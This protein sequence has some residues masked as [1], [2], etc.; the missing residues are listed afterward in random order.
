LHGELTRIDEVGHMTVTGF[1]LDHL[2]TT[3]LPYGSD[4]ISG[5]ISMR[6]LYITTPIVVGLFMLRDV[7]R[8]ISLL[9]LACAAF[10]IASNAT[11]FALAARVIPPLGYSRFPAA[12]YRALV[13]LPLLVLGAQA[14]VE[15]RQAPP[16]RILRAV[17]FAAF[18]AL[19]MYRLHETS[20]LTVV[21]AAAS[22]TLVVL[23]PRWP[24]AL[25]FTV[26]L[27]AIDAHHMHHAVEMPWI[28]PASVGPFKRY[29]RELGKALTSPRTSRPARSPARYEV[30]HGSPDLE[31][32]LRGHYSNDDYAASEHLRAVVAA[33][34][35]PA[36][37]DFLVAASHPV[38]LPSS[39][40][41][42]GP[43]AVV[44]RE[45]VGTARTV[46]FSA[47]R[48]EYALEVPPN[49]IVVENEP[50]MMGWS[51]ELDC[52]PSR[53][54]LPR[55]ELYPLRTWSVPGGTQRLC[56]R[57]ETPKRRFGS[58]VSLA[59]LALYLGLLIYTAR[60]RRT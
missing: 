49:A 42:T 17:G 26:P 9:M 21:I 46:A 2:F 52:D 10:A 45:P 16:H 58:A 50:L 48:I 19:G 29:A 8:H 55:A 53:Q 51:G 40:L 20:L 1:G 39:A 38:V 59:S 44:W 4:R 54:V 34:A 3:V 60:S 47:D 13:A 35:M 6:S 28:Q 15:L 37:S 5:D 7:R 36:V 22:L 32:Y 14:L 33:R 23:V 27:L 57:Y 12:D 11:L 25:V 30:E 18:V 24:L 31:G 56:V 43:S 41:F